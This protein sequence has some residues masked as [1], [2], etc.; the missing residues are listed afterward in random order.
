MIYGYDFNDVYSI[1]QSG[2]LKSGSKTGKSMMYGSANS[3]YTYLMI[4]AKLRVFELDPLLL[5]E[6]TS[7]IHVGWKAN[8]TKDSIKIIGKKYTRE[9]LLTFL[10]KFK[11]Q[12]EIKDI[13]K[14]GNPMT[15]EILVKN[16]INLKKFLK[17]IRLDPNDFTPKQIQLL[18]EI[19][20]EK[21]PNTKLVFE[22]YVSLAASINK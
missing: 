3:K 10:R 16:N 9:K 2:F 4:D 15:H 11:N 12:K 6:N 8:P 5:L 22:K 7:F 14:T 20:E 19:V 13:A 1:L 18:R 17:N 21:Y